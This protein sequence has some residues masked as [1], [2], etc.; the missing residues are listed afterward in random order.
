MF[1]TSA[2]LTSVI[3][4]LGSPLSNRQGWELSILSVIETCQQMP[5]FILFIFFCMYFLKKFSLCPTIFI[6]SGRNNLD[7]LTQSS[8]LSE[9]IFWNF[10]KKTEWNGTNYSSRSVCSI[11]LLQPLVTIHLTMSH[12]IPLSYL[13]FGS[14]VS[15]GPPR[16][17]T[18]FLFFPST[19]CTFCHEYWLWFFCIFLP[20]FLLF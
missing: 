12:M 4:T 8:V 5:N 6:V 17:D 2:A 3:R 1:L 10:R 11:L 7:F 9:F 20:S 14:S 19:S 13:L 16:M 15:K 18:S